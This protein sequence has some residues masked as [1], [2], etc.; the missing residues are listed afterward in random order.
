M[1]TNLSVKKTLDGSCTLYNPDLDET[2]HSLNGALSES[3]HVYIRN[4]LDLIECK[5]PSTCNIL[6][7]GFGTGMNALLT[8][9]ERK[10]ESSINYLSLEPF[11]LTVDLLKAYYNEFEDSQLNVDLLKEMIHGNSNEWKSV[12]MGFDF[13]LSDKKLQDIDSDDLLDRQSNPMLF[14]LIYYDAFAPSRQPEMWTLETLSK[15]VSLMKPG[16]ILTTYCAQ[17]QFKRNLKALGL[18]I[19][20]PNG[21]NGKREMTVGYR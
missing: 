10:P 15:A 5:N 17:G 13:N 6:E 19:E 1:N 18:K 11:P 2:Y 8:L 9:R 3:L 12:D 16:G 7:I 21:A 20:S 14:D 4:G